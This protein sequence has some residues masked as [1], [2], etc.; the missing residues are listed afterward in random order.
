MLPI[1]IP[2][3]DPINNCP[4]NPKSKFPIEACPKPAT[5]VNGT[6]ISVPTSFGV[7]NSGYKKNKVTVPNAPAPIEVKVTVAPSNTPIATVKTF[8]FCSQCE[9][10]HQMFLGEIH[11]FLLKKR[12]R[13]KSSAQP[14]L[15]LIGVQL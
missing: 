7:A 3:S 1:N 8:E 2:G 14:K 5:K 10:C 15:Y 13:G 9:I 12:N 4:N 6:A 11:K